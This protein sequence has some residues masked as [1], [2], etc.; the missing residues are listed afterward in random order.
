MHILPG[1]ILLLVHYCLFHGIC[2]TYRTAEIMRSRPRN[3]T[4]PFFLSLIKKKRDKSRSRRF[5]CTV[6]P[7][8]PLIPLPMLVN[9]S[10]CNF[11]LYIVHYV[12]VQLLCSYI[13]MGNAFVRCVLRRPLPVQAVVVCNMCIDIL[14]NPTHG[15]KKKKTNPINNWSFVSC[16]RISYWLR[17]KTNKLPRLQGLRE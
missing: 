9:R 14:T 16:R 3:G 11:S 2:R 5:A 13:F 4:L 10:L 12:H 7:L 15:A 6:I 17:M 1:I 8:A